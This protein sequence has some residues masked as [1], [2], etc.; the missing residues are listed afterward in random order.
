VAAF[1]GEIGGRQVNRDA[2]LRQ[3]D[4]DCLKG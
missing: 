2:P 1:L 4:G 3:A